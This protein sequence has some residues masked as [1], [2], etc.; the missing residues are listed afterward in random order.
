VPWPGVN[1]V[2]WGIEIFERFSKILSNFT[3]G[4]ANGMGSLKSQGNA[5]GAGERQ[6]MT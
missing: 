5:A 2:N 4:C 3:P 6:L 1:P